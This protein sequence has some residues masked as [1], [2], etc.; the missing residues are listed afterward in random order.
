[1]GLGREK[2][3]YL[4]GDMPA[5]FGKS[6]HTA[7]QERAHRRRIWP[8]VAAYGITAALMLDAYTWPGKPEDPD[9]PSVIHAWDMNTKAWKYSKGNPLRYIGYKY[10][11]LGRDKLTA[12]IELAKAEDES[13]GLIE[14]NNTPDPT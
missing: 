4:R 8:E 2:K 5:L 13:S 11:D 3:V 1:M 7:R 12:K 6:S 10:T 9:V 14:D